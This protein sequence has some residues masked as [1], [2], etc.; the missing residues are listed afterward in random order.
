MMILARVAASLTS[1]M[2]H[3]RYHIVLH[4]I[5]QPRRYHIVL[6]PISQPRRPYSVAS[7]P[8]SI[9]SIQEKEGLVQSMLVLNPGH[10]KTIDCRP[11]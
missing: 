6:H 5:S 2:D 10:T 11:L 3:R 9:L 7:K 8:S 1:Q 4:P